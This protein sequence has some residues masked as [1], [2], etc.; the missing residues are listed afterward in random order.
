M[1]GTRVMPDADGR[2]RDL[3]PGEYGHATLS[4]EYIKEDSPCN[5][6]VICAPNGASCSLSPKIHQLVENP[7]GTLTV[8]PS[9]LIN[10]AEPH[11]HGYLVNGEFKDA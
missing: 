5:W 11:W 4:R 3:L 2:L 8:T 9:I 6:W 10:F 7:D 1:K